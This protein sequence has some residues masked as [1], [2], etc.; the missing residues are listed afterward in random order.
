MN[1]TPMH[2][3][4]RPQKSAGREISALGQQSWLLVICRG[5]T[6]T[7]YVKDIRLHRL[8]ADE[9]EKALQAAAGSSP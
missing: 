4:S 8:S 5:K 3:D 7:V 2:R 1:L 6:M 9:A